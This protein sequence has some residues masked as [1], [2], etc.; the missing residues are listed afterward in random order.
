MITRRRAVIALGVGSVAVPLASFAQQRT[1]GVT[2]IGVLP[3]GSPT[4]PYDVS[5]VDALRKGH[6]EFGLVDDRAVAIDVLWVSN[7]SE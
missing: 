3:I 5:L 2:R 6:R 4:N 1:P 7:E